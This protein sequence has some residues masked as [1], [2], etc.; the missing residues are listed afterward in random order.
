MADQVW[1][2]PETMDDIWKFI[3]LDDKNFW[4]SIFLPAWVVFHWNVVSVQPTLF[5]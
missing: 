2:V 4:M 3:D 5:A 1:R